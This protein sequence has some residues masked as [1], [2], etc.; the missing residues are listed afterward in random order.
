MKWILF[1]LL[2][3]HG[4]VHLLGFGQAFGPRAFPRIR[5]PISRLQGL[6]WL[7]TSAALLCAAALSFASP[8][9]WWIVGAGATVLSQILIVRAWSDAKFGTLANVV[10]LAG[11]IHGFASQG[12]LSF[13]ATYRD[14]VATRLEHQRAAP[15][16][17]EADLA[18]LPDPVRCYVR[19]SGALGRPRPTHAAA[20]WRGR[21]RGS[22]T[23]PWMELTAEQHDFFDE[24]S[25]FF[26]MEAERGG[27]PVDVLH[28]FAGQAASMRVRLLSLVP[29]V[30][31]QGRD[32]TRAET[33]T[34]LNDMCMLAPGSLASPAI[35]WES[36][37]DRSARAHY[38]L[39]ENTVSGT[40][41]FD[42]AC[43]LV[44]F[45]SDD[46]LASSPDG[47]HFTRQRWST[48]LWGYRNFGP[49]RAASHGEARWHPD[50]GSY[51]YIELELVSLAID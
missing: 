26:L 10:V 14:E 13:R 9:W 45:V 15:Y 50:E 27:L 11:V 6:L 47:E 17:R 48:P 46:R 1:A 35:R 7:V 22:E 36:I 24:P 18:G 3:L 40:L 2:L 51:A 12:P 30:E 33:V 32:A 44:D 23:D 19:A 37:D 31:A 49:Y 34:L 8:R 21:I 25:R 38:T 4:L 5:R 41:V 42:D 16:L 43:E 28:V 39:G 29:I 20:K